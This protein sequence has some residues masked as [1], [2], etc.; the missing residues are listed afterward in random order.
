L[1]RALNLEKFLNLIIDK[2]YMSKDIYDEIINGFKL[3]DFDE[4]GLIS[5]ENLRRARDET[6]MKLTDS[7]LREMMAEADHNGDGFVDPHEFITTMLKT[8][9]YSN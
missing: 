6:G 3:F 8:N 1:K 2:Q 4:N 9:L 5:E 7:E